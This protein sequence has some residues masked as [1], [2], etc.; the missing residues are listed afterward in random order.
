[1]DRLSWNEIRAR[2]AKFSEDWKDASY[3]KGE[4]QSFYNDFFQIFGQSRR[5]VAT[6]EEPVKKL[7]LGQG[8]IDLLWKG[9]LLVEQKSAGRNLEQ[10]R[11]QAFAYLHGLKD[12]ELPRYILACDFQNFEL[13][14]LEE[15][16]Q[17]SFKLV[18]LPKVVEEFGFI[19]GRN[20]R[21]FRDQDP[22]NVKA[23]RLMGRLHDKLFESNYRGHDLEQFLVRLLFCL[24][25]DDTGIFEPRDIF[26]DFIVTRTK[27]DGSDLGPLLAQLF[28]TLNEEEAH[29]PANLDEDLAR[30]QYINGDLFAGM[31]RLP[32]FDR[33]M[34]ELLIEACEFNWE[35]ISP[36]IF[37]ALFQHVSGDVEA[38]RALGEHYTTEKNIMKVIEPLFL[39]DLRKEL[40]A[41]IKRGNVTALHEFQKKLASLKMMDPACGC[42][43]FLIIAY[44]ELRLLETQ[45]LK[46]LYPEEKV[47]DV[48]TISLV[49]VDQFYGIEINEFPVRIAETA[50][51]M[52]DHIMN[53][54]LSSALG[55]VF[56]RIPLKK[57]PHIRH[58]DALEYPWADLLDP[59][60]CDYV[61]GNPP[62]L[63]SKFQ[64]K[65][66]RR[67]IKNIANLGGSGGTLDLV[68]GWYIKA[69]AYIN[70]H[71]GKI[72]F[73]STN[74]ITQGE[75]V[76]QLWPIL[77]DRFGLEIAFAHR[78]FAWGSDV[79]SVAHVHVVILGLVQQRD[80]PKVKQ[81]FEYEDI[82]GEPT[83]I[84]LSKVSPYLIDASRLADPHA[85]VREVNRPINGLRQI[86]SG[87]KPID[88][89]HYIFDQ[90]AYNDFIALEPGAQKFL[91]PYIGSKELINGTVRYI[92]CLQAAQ[93]D[94]LR[95]LPMTQKRIESVK[96]SRLQS[97]SAP[98]QAM[99]NIPTQF[100]V[101]VI[102][103]VQF[104]AIPEVSSEKRDYVPI[105]HLHPPVVPS[106]KVRILELASLREFGILTSRMHMAWT[107]C[108]SG[109]LKSDIQYGIGIVYNNFPVPVI[110]AA[111]S[112]KIEKLAQAVLDARAAHSSSTLADMYDPVLMP[113]DLRKAHTTLDKAVDRLY[114]PTGFASDRERVEHLFLLYEAMISPMA[115]MMQDP[116]KRRR[117]R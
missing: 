19:L 107:K 33:S 36:A 17:I 112:K 89:G 73:V 109:R 3:E 50:M 108:V 60:E 117:F 5:K 116:P 15:R 79:T 32:S 92:F 102:P 28:Q 101:T 67:Q 69:G 37:G 86:V 88:G 103:T 62:F 99:A 95:R 56:T 71:K 94:E 58:A 14:D 51:W 40:A 7:G 59:K 21:S 81:L 96:L 77:F 24:F 115:A 70:G 39:D 111:Q 47:L 55:Q 9:V 35:G 20:R 74:S 110:A 83:M 104:L 27:E 91:R 25:A 80:E 4:T 66:Q 41:V 44:R 1:M 114:K 84:E 113:P 65:A 52:M 78:T 61:L 18:E 26:L 106:N 29:R 100:H 48:S 11:A 45:V 49:D 16:R 105:A 57:A 13:F 43:N 6:F 98:T 90:D 22:V 75:Q 53:L 68:T 46:A 42:G 2:A 10:A 31:L 8:F 72:G 12:E 23:S 30:F 93:P 34:R 85:V 64:S 97:D 82:G 63:G 54:H 87:S 38:R 76:A